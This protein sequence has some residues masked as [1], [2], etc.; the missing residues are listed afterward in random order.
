MNY[1]QSTGKTIQQSF[2]EYHKVHNGWR[3]K[4]SF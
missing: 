2:N 4:T 3:V 1:H